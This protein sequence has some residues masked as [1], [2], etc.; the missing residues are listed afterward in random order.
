VTRRRRILRSPLIPLSSAALLIGALVSGTASAANPGS[1]TIT[2]TSGTSWDGE[3]YTR[4]VPDQ[5]ACPSKSADRTN[6]VCDHF[7]LTVTVPANY[8]ATRSG[9]AEV[10]ISWADTEDDFDL[11][12]YK[13][14][15]LVASSAQGNTNTEMATIDR[16]SGDYEVRV[17]PFLVTNSAYKGTAN[18]V[19]KPTTAPPLG[20]PAKYHGTR[21]TG[22]L[23]MTAPKNVPTTDNPSLPPLTLKFYPVGRQAAEPTI[24][25]DRTQHVDPTTGNTIKGYA[26]F[27]A[28]TFDGAGGLADTRIRRSASEGRTWEDKTPQPDLP[29]T[30]DPYVY[31]EEDENRVFNLD[32]YLANAYLQFS[33]KGGEPNSYTTNPIG[34]G[35][36]NFV[37]DHQTIFAGPKPAGVSVALTDPDFQ[38]ILYYCYNNI[39]STTCSR[40]VDGGVVFTPTAPAYPG[41]NPD[42]GEFCGGLSGHVRTDPDGRVFVPRGYCGVPTV[43]ISNNAGTSFNRVT[44][45]KTVTMGNLHHTAMSSDQ[46]GNLYYT[47]IDAKFGL[48]FLATSTDHGKTWSKP[49]MIAP[50]NVREI[51][52]FA[53]TVAA[54]ANGKIAI[55]FPG[56]TSSN[57][58]DLTRPWDYYVLY[59]TDALAANP[60]FVS[61]IANSATD[62]VHRGNCP[63]RCGNMLDFLDIVISPAPGHAIW[64]TAVDTCTSL[65]GCNSDPAAKGFDGSS[66]NAAADMQGMV[67][68]QVLGVPDLGPPGGC[69]RTCGQ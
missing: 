2:P 59:S 13:G 1:G 44:V 12:I 64:A 25:V 38:E 67:A 4:L 47:W 34:G 53:P 19:T 62:P 35:A 68:R 22:D 48:P 36:A 11:F 18:V 14:N 56:T 26:F 52:G 20:G 24:G 21:I 7:I 66:D 28:A 3:T 8:Y 46:A 32:L 45:S 39:A 55:S 29:V 65:K 41:V 60:T 54:G 50:P 31:V 61:N 58:G 5:N 51:A 10:K 69:S 40:S 30:L 23:P 16:A 17:S 42:T 43:A 6:A 15:T 37:Q 63:G 49:L 27:A 57:R 33:D 9:G